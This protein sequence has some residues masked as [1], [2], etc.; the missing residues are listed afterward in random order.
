MLEV[1]YEGTT[2]M[3]R[4]RKHILVSEYEVFRMEKTILELQTGFT[5][6]VNHLLGLGKT[7]QDD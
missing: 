7:F 3:T 2:D 5:H 1:N 4:L 6:I